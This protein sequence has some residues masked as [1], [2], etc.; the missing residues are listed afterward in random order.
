MFVLLISVAV[1]SDTA[2]IAVTK[3]GAQI[4]GGS[5]YNYYPSG[6]YSAFMNT[7]DFCCFY[8]DVVPAISTP[9]YAI[10]INSAK[11]RLYFD[12]VTGSGKCQAL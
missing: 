2:S 11:L 4:P 12:A 10:T 1:F 3:D 6:G 9:G 7:N 5:W 8:A